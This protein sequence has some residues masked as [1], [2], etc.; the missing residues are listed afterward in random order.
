MAAAASVEG[1][2]VTVPVPPEGTVS[3]TDRDAAPAPPR[4]WIASGLLSWSPALTAGGPNLLIV[5]IGV[6]S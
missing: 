6:F 2:P 3:V 1:T 5:T 4:F